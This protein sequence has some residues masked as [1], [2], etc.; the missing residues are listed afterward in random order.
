MGTKTYFSCSSFKC[1][2]TTSC[3]NIGFVLW[4]F[5]QCFRRVILSTSWRI[6]LFLSTNSSFFTL[7]FVE[8]ICYMLESKSISIH[9]SHQSWK[10]LE[11]P[12]IWKKSWK[13]LESPKI[14][15]KFWKSPG[16]FL[17]FFLWLNGP[18][19]RFLNKHQ[20]F[21]DFLCMLNVAIH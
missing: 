20:H 10:V 11:S 5:I 13:V 6:F 8:I 14:L 17:E 9:G 21:S 7:E 12:E 18:E 2:I 15:L 3:F 1:S 16:T 4:T 19:E